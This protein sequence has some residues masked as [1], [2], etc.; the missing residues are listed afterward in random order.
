MYGLHQQIVAPQPSSTWMRMR[1]I[2]HTM[3]LLGGLGYAIYWV[4]K[5]S[6]SV[7][8]LHMFKLFSVVY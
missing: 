3:A 7:V 6:N 4:Y 2:L 5:V 8:C 1:D